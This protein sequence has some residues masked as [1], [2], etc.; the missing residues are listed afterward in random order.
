MPEEACED[1]V[2]HKVFE[3]EIVICSKLSVIEELNEQDDPAHQKV[4]ESL[5]AIEVLKKSLQYFKDQNGYLND[6][7]EKLMIS[8]SRLR[9]DLEEINA[10]YQ[11]LIKTSK[12]VL[13]RKR[14]TQQ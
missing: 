3:F 7:N 9:E 12:E 10:R 6:S 14:L 13:R 5:S 1:K 4:M 2:K 8:N 11:E